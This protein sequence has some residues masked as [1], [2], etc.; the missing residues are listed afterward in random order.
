MKTEQIITTNL[1][2]TMLDE[3][4]KSFEHK[5]NTSLQSI[6]SNIQTDHTKSSPTRKKTA[7]SAN[8]DQHP[9]NQTEST[10]HQK[11]NNNQL[12]NHNEN[13]PCVYNPYDK[14]SLRRRSVNPTLS[15][16]E[17]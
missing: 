7:L 8:T 1:L 11:T 17:S 4:E 3:R 9:T 10:S 12:Q 16:M 15:T 13:S 6:I 2:R 14:T 5:M